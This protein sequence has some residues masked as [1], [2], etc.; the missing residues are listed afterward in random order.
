MFKEI[1]GSAEK[2]S[3][4]D[5]KVIHKV[6]GDAR[7]YRLGLV[8]TSNIWSKDLKIHMYEWTIADGLG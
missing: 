2:Y 1:S 8:E 5:F 4:L 3:I 7:T 6:F